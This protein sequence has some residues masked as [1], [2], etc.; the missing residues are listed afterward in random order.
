MLSKASSIKKSCY[1]Y[2]SLDNVDMYKLA[3]VHQNIPCGSRVIS[4]FANCGRTD[5]RTDSQK[6]SPTVQNDA[7]SSIVTVLHNIDWT[8]LKY[9]N[10]QHLNKI[11]Q[12]VQEL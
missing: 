8:M 7:R 9:I 6:N 2:Q 12:A 1:A 4:I 10:I 5:E 3:K 11:I